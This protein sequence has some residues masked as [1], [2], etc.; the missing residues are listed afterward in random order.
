MANFKKKYDFNIKKELIPIQEMNSS[1]SKNEDSLMNSILNDDEIKEE[2]KKQ[3][4]NVSLIIEVK[5]EDKKDILLSKPYNEILRKKIKLNLY[6]L[7]LYINNFYYEEFDFSRRCLYFTSS[8]PLLTYLLMTFRYRDHPLR[9]TIIVFNTLFSFGVFIYF[10]QSDII[11][12]AN[13]NTELGVKVKI[14]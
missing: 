13:Q 1:Q 8:I 14:K 11:N 6:L 12:C 10:Y 3:Q 4:H 7:K 5:Q 9:R 2:N